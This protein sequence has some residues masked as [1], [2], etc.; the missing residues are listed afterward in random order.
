MA[1]GARIWMAGAVT[2][3]LLAWPAAAGAADFGIE[4]FSIATSTAQAGAHPDVTV[5]TAFPAY[6][7]AATPRVRNVRL[8]LPAGLVGNPAASPERCSQAQFDASACPTGS[9]VGSVTVRATA[10]VLGLPVPSTVT[11]SVFN[12]VPPA[13]EPAR[14]GFIVTPPLGADIRVP[15]RVALRPADGGLDSVMTDLPTTAT[16][17]GVAT[18]LYTERVELTLDGAASGGTAFMTNPTSCGQHTAVLEASP[19]AGA[20]D[21]A[22]AS[23]QTTGCGAVPFAPAA[24]IA[25]E[26]SRRGS[27]SGYSVTLT[28]PGGESPV[29]QA[30]VRRTEVVLPEGTTLSPGVANGLEACTD[31]QFGLGNSSPAQCPAASRIGAVTFAT[32][33]LAEPLHGT[34]FF[35]AATPARPLGLFVAVDEAGVRLKLA[36]TVRLDPATGRISTVFDDLPQV[37]FTSFT[38]SFQGGAKAVLANPVGCG[39]Q[40]MTTRLTP[41]SGGADATPSATFTTDADGAGGACSAPAFRPSLGL[42]VADRSAGRPAGA[43]TLRLSRPDGDQAIGRVVTEFPPGLAGSLAGVGICPED[44]A[45]TGACPAD[46]RVGS[47]SATVGSGAEP[48]TLGGSVFLTGPAEG[49]LVGLAIVIPG[50]VGP[51]DLGT[52]VTR[53]GIVLRPGDGGLTVRTAELPRVVGGVPIAIRALAL[54]LDRPGFMRNATSCGP[55]AVTATFTSQSGATATATAPYQAERCDALAF[56]PRISAT[57]GGRGLTGPKAKPALTT[58]VT[59][60]PGQAATRAVS[61]TLPT[62]TGVDLARLESRCKVE[63]AAADA[64]PP[65]ARVGRVRADTS[66]LPVPLTGDV[67]LADLAG[68]SLPGLL[69]RFTTP[70]RLDLAGTVQFTPKG[71]KS[72]FA[73]VPDV[74]LERFE[75]ALDGGRSGALVLPTG[76]DL[77]KDPRPSIRGE[78]TA[79]SGRTATHSERVAIAG[80]GPRAKLTVARLGSARPSLTLTVT[81]SAG[82]ADLGTV[83]LRLPGA[84]RV[85]PRRVARGLRA[86]GDGRRINAALTRKGVLTARAPEGAKRIVVQVRKGA[87]RASRK[88]RGRLTKRPRLRFGLRVAPATGAA[89]IGAAVTRQTLVVRVKR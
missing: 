47:V 24:A 59:V 69:V 5:V 68:Q 66:L 39:E 89:G 2:A 45:A 14:L 55:L 74:P 83:R 1:S 80:C 4:E 72:T 62:G 22:S 61:V 71:V 41:W 86:R 32:P 23:F 18:P 35:A 44:R 28:V 16:I 57:L 84:L 58:V 26:T 79:H 53:A 52:V 51:I 60:P 78:F 12:I 63:Q 31:E 49:G 75:L 65:A 70:A 29:R 17:A 77:C 88:L 85:Q 81:R 82:D 67:Y 3:A 73:G 64:C 25:T 19:Y 42:E 7:G 27:P 50:R 21:S 56:S 43:V 15:I 20:A 34:V 76:V 30:H 38:L 6:D 48:V 13:G 87:F 40:R 36:G 54:T 46:A 37:P 11:G 9:V 10:L 8:G 33:V